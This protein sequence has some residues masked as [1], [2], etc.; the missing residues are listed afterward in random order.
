VLFSPRILIQF[1]GLK[2]RSGHHVGWCRVV[3]VGLDA[4]PQGM[5][6]FPRQA[7]L[8]REARRGLALGNPAQQ[9]H[10]GGRALPSLVEDRARQQRI[11]AI[12]SPTAVGWELPLGTEQAPLGAT[13]AGACEPIR[14]QV[15]LQP[16][17]A[18][19]L[20]QKF[21]YRKIDHMSMILWC[22]RWL[23][24]SH[25]FLF[26]TSE[27]VIRVAMI[28]LMVRRLAGTVSS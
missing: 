21:A 12:A 16:D 4:L 22:A 8:V 11:V 6:L 7:Q 23:H 17:Q 10:Q 15:A 9:Q 2:G 19:T 27:T 24:M 25:E 13:T 3:Q 1:I 28:H 20:I 14:M 18:D 26:Q 5:E